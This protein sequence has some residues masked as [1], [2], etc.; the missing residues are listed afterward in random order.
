MFGSDVR[1]ERILDI[2]EKLL[3]LATKQMQ[4]NACWQNMTDKILEKINRTLKDIAYQIHHVDNGLESGLLVKFQEAK[5][6]IDDRAKLQ[7]E[8]IKLKEILNRKNRR[9]E[10]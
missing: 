7:A 4:E 5:R 9:A 3:S 2:T 1:I 8:V 6:G 10:K